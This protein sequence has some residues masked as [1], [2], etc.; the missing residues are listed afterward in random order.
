MTEMIPAPAPCPYRPETG[1]AALVGRIAGLRHELDRATAA[2]DRAGIELEAERSARIHAETMHDEALALLR[3]L[4]GRLA[5]EKRVTD[6]LRRA[7]VTRL[8]HGA[9]PFAL[10]GL[11]GGFLAVVALRLAGW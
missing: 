3:E 7:L 6:W 8:L 5:D 4:R 11:V 2:R 9:A 10:A 1:H